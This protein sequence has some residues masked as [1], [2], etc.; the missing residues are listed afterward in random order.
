MDT[1]DNMIAAAE[2]TETKFKN[3]TAGNDKSRWANV[4]VTF[5]ESAG[6]VTRRDAESASNI[7]AV[8]NAAA[9]PQEFLLLMQRMF[10]GMFT[11]GD[12]PAQESTQDRFVDIIQEMLPIG[13]EER[14]DLKRFLGRQI[15]E[16]EIQAVLN[17]P[18]QL[19]ELIQ[20]NF[21][22]YNIQ[23]EGIMDRIKNSSV[24]NKIKNSRVG[25]MV[26]GARDMAKAGASLSRGK[27]SRKNVYGQ[28]G[29]EYDDNVDRGKQ[30][31]K[32]TGK[33]AMK[34]AGTGLRAAGTAAAMAT[35]GVDKLLAPGGG[36]GDVNPGAFG[37]LMNQFPVANP[38]AA[39]PKQPQL[40]IKKGPNL[41]DAW[42]QPGFEKTSAGLE[43]FLTNNYTLTDEQLKKL[44]SLRNPGAIRNT[45]TTIS[46]AAIKNINDMLQ[47]MDLVEQTLHMD[48]FS[49]MI[50]DTGYPIV[51][52][53]ED[54]TLPPEPAPGAEV[55]EAPAAPTPDQSV[56]LEPN[57]L[58]KLQVD[59]LEL[60]RKAL[61]INPKDIDSEAYMKITT[62]VDFN[63]LMEL[64]P[65]LTKLVQ[66]HYPDLEMDEVTPGPGV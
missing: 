44:M 31:L 59:M 40:E 16:H 63:N 4:F 50:Q 48:T 6:V 3:Y 17:N 62:A 58:D 52:A 39:T 21:P 55:P 26:G 51:E 66:N 23:L 47:Q 5:F 45:G 53:P 9:E 28:D 46:N 15:T 30:A 65:L 60:V 38:A 22:E 1:F 12:Q 19:I 42:K 41:N 57:D 13:D 61:I 43:N 54:E 10:P 29:A 7:D 20:Q 49:K 24:V 34:A 11:F 36:S 18:Q 56:E 2:P 37:Q 35:R 8:E 33:G 25:K 32:S 27:K 14:A 64:R